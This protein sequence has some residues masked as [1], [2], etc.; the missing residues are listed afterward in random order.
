MND[1]TALP[2]ELPARTVPRRPLTFATSG[3]WFA[4][5]FL[6]TLFAFWPTYFSKLPAR[7]DVYTHVHAVLMT[8][9]FGLL[10]AQPFLIRRERR[11]WH[12][13]LGRTSFVLVPLIA[14]TWVLLI[15]ARA[16]A[17]PEAVFEREGK[18][19]YLPFVSSFLFIASWVMA[20]L[21]RRVPGLHARYMVCTAFAAIDAVL[22]RLLFFNLPPF[23]NPFVYQWVGFGVTDLVIGLLFLA[24]RGPHRRAFAHMF[25]L[26]TLMHALWFTA[27]QGA[28]W[29][30][31]VRWFRALPLT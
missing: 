24:D 15:H 2:G 8:A 29:L 25:V 6:V 4:A 18:F 23:S 31:L 13:R 28:A 30:A 16:S 21:R 7:M 19:F 20:I 3:Y 1:D 22:A 14:V 5:F 27:A 17:M 9:W 26:F 11:V 12:R 10:V